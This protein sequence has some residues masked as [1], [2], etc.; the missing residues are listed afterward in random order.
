M[1][2]LRYISNELNIAVSDIECRMSEI[3]YYQ[4][5]IT[6]AMIITAGT[7][8]GVVRMVGQAVHEFT[9][10]NGIKSKPV[11]LGIAPWGLLQNAG[12]LIDDKVGTTHY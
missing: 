1:G 9:L 3:Y 5:V 8:S 12:D 11:T 7:S 10:A 2:V 6:G 4:L